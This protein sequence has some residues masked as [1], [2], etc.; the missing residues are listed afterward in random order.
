M[1]QTLAGCAFCDAPPG[2]ESGEAYIWGKYERVSHSIC[3]GCAIK[4]RPGSDERE[5]Y[6][7]DGCGLVVDA[8]A[9]LAR[10]RVQLGHLEGPLRFCVRCSPGGPATY[11]TRGLKEHLVTTPA[12]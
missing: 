5:H 4:T 3:V 11:W 6:A 7:P 9:A 2:T 8:L 1:Q 10:F 12:E